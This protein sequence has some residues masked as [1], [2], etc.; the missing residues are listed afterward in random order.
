[1]ITGKRMKQVLKQETGYKE[2]G[3]HTSNLRQGTICDLKFLCTIPVLIALIVW[4]YW[5]TLISLNNTWQMNDNYSSG[6]IVP[7]VALYFLWRKRNVLSQ[8]R[9][10]PCWRGGIAVVFTAG[11]MHFLAVLTD[12]GTFGRYSLIVMISGLVLWI[13]GKDVIRHIKWI[14][15]F[16]IL[17]VPLPSSIDAQISPWL[18]RIATK[19]S[20]YLLESFGIQLEC[21][22][23][24]I[25]LN[26]NMTIGVA[27]ACSGLR[28]LTAFVV[29]SAFIA[30]MLDRSKTIKTTLFLSSIPL[31]VA[32]NVIRIV[33]TVIIISYVS[34]ELGEKFFHDFAGFFMM[35]VAVLLLFCELRLIDLLFEDSVKKSN[36]DVVKKKLKRLKQ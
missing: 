15:A 27:E 22:G 6:Q 35:P 14:L 30:Y 17:A 11:I 26:D 16:L 29:V 3:L 36:T 19:G 33:A 2:A 23:N 31:S 25:V 20:V 9:I 13:G 1:M 4:S 28:M 7:M 21:Q 24:T 34:K 5:P 32:C 18:Q 12:R 8:C 10:E